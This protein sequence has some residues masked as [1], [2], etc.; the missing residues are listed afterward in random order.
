MNKKHKIPTKA[1]LE[2]MD[3]LHLSEDVCVI[4]NKHGVSSLTLGCND[5]QC[6]DCFFHTYNIKLMLI[7]LIGEDN[8]NQLLQ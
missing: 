4:A 7:K 2:W 5:M 6:C 8:T 1:K 3:D